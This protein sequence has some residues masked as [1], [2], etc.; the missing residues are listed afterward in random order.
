MSVGKSL[1]RSDIHLCLG[2]DKE[3]FYLT[4]DKKERFGMKKSEDLLEDSAEFIALCTPV[5]DEDMQLLPPL[6]VVLFDGNYDNM[7]VEKKEQERSD[8]IRRL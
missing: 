5:T 6:C 7:E 1:K 2:E 4:I 8:D 3:I